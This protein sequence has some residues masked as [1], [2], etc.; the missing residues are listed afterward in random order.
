MAESQVSAAVA[1]Q[2]LE[3]RAR[4]GFGRGGNAG[5]G[6]IGLSAVIGALLFSVAMPLV[7]CFAWALSTQDCYNAGLIIRIR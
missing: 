2:A 5:R 1:A 6:G 7:N 4:S 3:R